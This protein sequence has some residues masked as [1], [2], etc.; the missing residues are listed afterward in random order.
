[1]TF[2]AYSNS[3]IGHL[4]WN[5]GRNSSVSECDTFFEHLLCC[6]CPHF[7][8]FFITHSILPVDPP[9]IRLLGAPQIDVEEGKDSLVLRCEADANPP[10]SIVWK[11]AGRS[12]I[13]S[14]QVSKM[15]IIFSP[16]FFVV[17]F[18]VASI[19]RCTMNSM[20]C[21]PLKS[22]KFN[23]IGNNNNVNNWNT[24]NSIMS[25]DIIQEQLYEAH[26]GWQFSFWLEWFSCACH[27]IP[28]TWLVACSLSLRF[29]NKSPEIITITLFLS[30]THSLSLVSICLRLF[31]I[32][33]FALWWW[34]CVHRKR[35]NWDR[36]DDVMPVCTHVKPRTRLEAPNNYLF[37][38]I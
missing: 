9:T 38:W 7:D 15:L 13:A 31:F 4:Q 5:D 3:H 12:E 22:Q 18:D 8:I 29:D 27:F 28:Q 6:F 21:A 10:A 20:V 19:Y 35:Y 2:H 37:N 17:V 33:L 11:R 1:M 23:F 32:L 14:L 24:A 36:S 25:T 34:W 16:F 30:L 26:F